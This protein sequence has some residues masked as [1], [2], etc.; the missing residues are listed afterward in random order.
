MAFPAT[1]TKEQIAEE[2]AVQTVQ[3]GKASSRKA[4]FSEKFARSNSPNTESISDI[5]TSLTEQVTLTSA[6]QDADVLFNF[7]NIEDIK[8]KSSAQLKVPILN[9]NGQVII[10]KTFDSATKSLIIN[11]ALKNWKTAAN[12]AFKHEKLFEYNRI[13]GMFTQFEQQQI[14]NTGNI[15]QCVA[16]PYSF[17]SCTN[18]SS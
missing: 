9:P 12:H 11:L 16:F 14:Y 1:W 5:D 17:V 10:L 2:S 15:F 8:G 7:C 18:Q 6:E 3:V 13:K 4:L